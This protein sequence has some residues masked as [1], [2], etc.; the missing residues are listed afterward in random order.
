MKKSD[1]DC[2]EILGTRLSKKKKIITNQKKQVIFGATIILNMKLIVIEMRHY[3]LKS[4]LIKFDHRDI[5][6]EKT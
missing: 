4:I 5:K 6:S 1:R 2:L 3:Y